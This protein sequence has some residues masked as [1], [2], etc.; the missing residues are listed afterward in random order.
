MPVVLSGCF[1]HH[2]CCLGRGPEWKPWWKSFQSSISGNS[3]G[4][5]CQLSQQVHHYPEGYLRGWCLQDS[6]LHSVG[7]SQ[8]TSWKWPGGTIVSL[9][10]T[11]GPGWHF[12]SLPCVL[13]I[14]Y[15]LG[16][17]GY[18][19]LGEITRRPC[20]KAGRNPQNGPQ[21]FKITHPYSK[22]F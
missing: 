18:A 20:P 12:S 5:V 13:P 22:M 8:H 10:G 19:R 15:S 2:K 1:S 17:L 9:G 16:I 4:P 11:S 14:L 3:A 6:P 21:T 7:L